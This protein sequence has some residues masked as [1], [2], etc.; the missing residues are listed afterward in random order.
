MVDQPAALVVLDVGADLP[1]RFG[2]PVRVE[3]VVLRLEV[4]AQGDEDV[5]RLA[6]VR[7]RGELEVVEGKRD[8]EVEGVIRRFVGDDEVELLH[9]EVPQVDFVLRR[10]EQIAQL[11]KL[12]LERRRVE[13]LEEVGIGGM[14]AEMRFE[15]AVDAGFE[16]E[17]VVDGDGADAGLL[18]PAGLAAAGVGGVH[19]VI[20]DEEEGLEELGEPAEG[21]GGGEVGGGEGWGG[22]KDGGG[23]E[24]GDAAVVFPAEGVVVE[25]LFGRRGLA[26]RSGRLGE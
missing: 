23:V 4:L 6:E 25:A 16:E 26:G 7:R 24:D 12:R 17:A 21:G 1:D 13:E 15:Q 18:V 5:A 11:P 14:R 20:G 22:K 2:T 3:V 8:G 9:A 19:Y 10:R